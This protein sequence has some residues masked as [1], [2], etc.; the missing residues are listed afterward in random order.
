MR[1]SGAFLT[2]G[3]DGGGSKIWPHACEPGSFTRTIGTQYLST[4]RQRPDVKYI[5][6]NCSLRCRNIVNKKEDKQQQQYLDL[7]LPVRNSRP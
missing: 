7:L 4:I 5:Q 2:A 6:S 3:S 1:G